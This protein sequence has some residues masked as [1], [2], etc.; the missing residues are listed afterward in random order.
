MYKKL[1]SSLCS[2]YIW[3]IVELKIQ[4]KHFL[5]NVSKQVVFYLDGGIVLLTNKKIAFSGANWIRLRI[6][7]MNCAIVISLGTKNLRL[8][9]S[10]ICD[11][12]TRST[13]T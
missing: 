9:I 6:I 2:A 5:D 7:H 11:F 12:G 10:G 13:T 8:S 3:P 1:S 4:W